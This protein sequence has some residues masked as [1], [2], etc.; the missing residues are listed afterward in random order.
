MES[1]CLY[2]RCLP[3][4]VRLPKSCGNCFQRQNDFFAFVFI[5]HAEP[6]VQSV[7]LTF[8]TCGRRF[9]GNCRRATKTVQEFFKHF[10]LSCSIFYI[11]FSILP[12]TLSLS[13][14]EI[15]RSRR[16]F[17][18]CWRKCQGVFF[19]YSEIENH[20]GKDTADP[21]INLQIFNFKV[22]RRHC[23]FFSTP[24]SKVKKWANAFFRLL[25]EQYAFKTRF[26]G[27]HRKV[28]SASR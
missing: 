25:D 24:I 10:S 17:L 4:A 23:F 2:L 8:G 26:G 6:H 22:A 9:H 13:S 18:W 28:T 21:A 14:S 11:T 3:L 7:H 12:F 15:E 19:F 20:V 5:S 16:L 27:K 1:D